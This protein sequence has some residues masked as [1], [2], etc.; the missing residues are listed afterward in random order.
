MSGLCSQHSIR[1]SLLAG[2]T[3]RTKVERW[4]Y[5]AESSVNADNF[6]KPEKK[7]NT[8][9]D[10]QEISAFLFPPPAKFAGPRPV[11]ID[12]HGGPEKQFG[13]LLKPRPTAS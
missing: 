9:F 12:I 3:D 6:S 5:T 2:Y 13:D 4:T 1:R 11:V 8:S 10:G 7:S